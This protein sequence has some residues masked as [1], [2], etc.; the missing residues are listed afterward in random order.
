MILRPFCSE[1]IKEAWCR[2]LFYGTEHYQ[3]MVEAADELLRLHE[4]DPNAWPRDEVW[5]VWAEL[6]WRWCEEMKETRRDILREMQDD[7]PTIERLRC[8]FLARDEEGR[9]RLSLPTTY[10]LRDPDGYF[11]RDILPRRQREVTRALWQ[12]AHK[13]RPTGQGG[14]RAGDVD[15]DG[16]HA[17]DVKKPKA[18]PTG[19][20]LLGA[21]L[22]AKEAGRSLDQRPR[23]P[24]TQRY[25]CWEANTHLGCKKTSCSHAHV[26]IG[27]PTTLDYTIRMQLNRRHG[28]KLESKVS[29][30][31]SIVRFVIKKRRRRRRP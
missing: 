31:S 21:P 8:F 1:V 5:D 25:V 4:D 20:G 9:P 17:G 7:N 12:L 6:S 24:A 26:D 22:S 2:G 23:D 11:Q 30:T 14:G 29:A 3:P 15:Q 19:S 27:K 16:H 28:H 18:L 13:Q 10:D